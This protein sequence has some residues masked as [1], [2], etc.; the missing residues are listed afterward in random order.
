MKHYETTWKSKDGL[1][2]FAQA[3]GPDV[4]QPRAVVC[5]VH[6]LGEHSGRYAHVAEALSKEGMI[7]F[8]SDLRGH[9]KSGGARGHINSIED[10]MGDIDMLF[11]QAHTRYTGL[12]L[13]LYGHSLGG[14]LVL[15]YGLKK[16]PN[17][18]GVLATSAG[19]HTALENQPVKIF[20]AKALGSILPTTSLASGLDTNG[21]SRDKTVVDAYRADPLNH[22]QVTLGFGKIMIDEVKWT[23]DHAKD[24]SYPLLLLHGKKDSIAFVSSSI[25]FAEPLKEKCT[26]VLW[27]EGLHE[28]HNEPEKAEVFKTMALWMDARLRE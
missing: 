15:H 17:V 16:K 14:I 9:G 27:D 26:L 7:L 19:L 25:E 10:F 20:L 3:W 23:L 22:N 4:V 18:K 6:G 5:L 1:D 12:P 24:F 28:L 21:L 2:I 8:T 11:E 13:F